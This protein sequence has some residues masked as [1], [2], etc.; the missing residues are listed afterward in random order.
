MT[1]MAAMPIYGK[2]PLKDFLPWNQWNNFNHI[3]YSASG[4]TAPYNLLKLLPWVDLDLFFVNVKFCNLG[5]DIEKNV[6]V[7]YSLEIIAAFDLEFGW[8]T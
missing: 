6:T 2:N 4:T 7:M 1:K 8:Y 5:F 3:W